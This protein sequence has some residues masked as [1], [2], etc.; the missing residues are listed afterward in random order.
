MKLNQRHPEIHSYSVIC[1]IFYIK[2]LSLIAFHRSNLL[3][4]FN[5]NLKSIS[6]EK[7]EG[8]TLFKF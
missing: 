7:L 1:S 3:D 6:K 4:S 5:F 8:K 2:S